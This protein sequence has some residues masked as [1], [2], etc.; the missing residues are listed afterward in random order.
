MTD[1]T[2]AP[3]ETVET[4]LPS[5]A[6]VL[7]RVADPPGSIQSVG[8]SVGDGRLSDAIAPIREVAEVVEAGIGSLSVTRARV[9]F[10]VSFSAKS[11]PLTAI[12][13]EGKGSASL[14]VTLDW[15]RPVESPCG[16]GS[17]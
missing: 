16:P 6:R 12:V 8:R 13:F 1:P 4:F 7:V 3:T 5:G 14:T 9:E 11:G 15:E 10:G 2:P 17:P